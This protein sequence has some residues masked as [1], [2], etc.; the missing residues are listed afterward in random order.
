[1]PGIVVKTGAFSGVSNGAL[2]LA[3]GIDEGEIHSSITVLEKNEVAQYDLHTG[4]ELDYP[5][6]FGATVSF[7]EGL[8]CIGGR[9]NQ[10]SYADVYLLNWDP[11]NKKI[12]KKVF[13]KLPERRSYSAAAII[14]GVVYVAGGID[15]LN[16]PQT[17]KNFWAL[18]LSLADKQWEVLETWPGSGRMHA[19]ATVQ[20]DGF[21]KIFHLTGGLE[22]S[23]EGNQ[24]SV[25]KE[26][27]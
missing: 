17:S 8:L 16:N 15:T 11:I 3:G 27:I 7:E 13:P 18:D 25:I 12:E 23:A 1:M 6:A 2:I 4:F 14:D 10:Q 5:L 24:L 9:D 19:L 22:I 21:Y 20:H 26:L